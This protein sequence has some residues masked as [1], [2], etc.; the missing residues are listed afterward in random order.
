[1]DSEISLEETNKLRVSLGLA[2]LGEG[3]ATNEAGEVVLDKDQE[4]EENYQK[5]REED[6]KAA[7]TKSVFHF[8]RSLAGMG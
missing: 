3:P 2:P 5:K 1:M 6:A 4:A 7:E 8:F